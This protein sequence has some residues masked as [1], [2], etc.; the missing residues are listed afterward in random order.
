MYWR[1]AKKL[2]PRTIEGYRTAVGNTLKVVNIGQDVNLSNLMANFYRE[3][4]AKCSDS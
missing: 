2:Q 3:R 4:G 1:D